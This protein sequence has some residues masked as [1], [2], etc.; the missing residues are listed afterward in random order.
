MSI[1]LRKN[2]VIS[3][4]ILFFVFNLQAK[5]NPDFP[6]I[7]QGHFPSV[8]VDKAD[9]EVVSIAANALAND[10]KSVTGNPS[11]VINNTEKSDVLIIAGTLGKSA[12]IDKLAK[13]HKINAKAIQG[14]WETYSI[15]YVYNPFNGVK[16][17][18]VVAGSDRRATAYGIFE[19]SKMMGVSPWVWWA[20]VLPEKKQEL[21]IKAENKVYGEPSVKYRGIFLNDED[22]GLKPWA[23]KNMDTDIKDIG[24]NTYAHIFELLLRLKANYIWPAMHDCTKAFYYYP[25]NPV[26][27]DKYAIVV[28]SS[29]CEPI[30]RNNVFEWA[31]NFENEYGTKPGEWRYDKNKAQIDKY[32]DDRA[33]QSA[34][35]ESVYTIGMRG[36]H[37]GSMPGPKDINQKIKLLDSVIVDQ[38][39][40][41][42]NRLHKPATQIPQIFCPYKEV[43]TLYQKGLDLPDDATIVWA[44]DNHGY[45]RQ[46]SNEKEQKR[47]GR[48][49]VY[50]HLSYWGSPHDYLWLSSVSPSL[51]SFEMTKAYDFGADRLWVFNVGDIKPAEAEIQFA[52][53]LAWDIN[54]WTPE[55]AREYSRYWAAETFGEKYADKIA[56]IKQTYYQLAQAAKPEHV[57]YVE[58]SVSEQNN[59]MEEYSNIAREAEEL[60]ADIPDYLQ[61]AYFQL[62]Y[63][64]VMGAKLMNEKIFY[65]QQSLVLMQKGDSSCLNYAGKS[66]SAFNQIQALTKQ[67]NKEISNGKWD[68]IMDWQPRRQDVFKMPETATKEGLEKV[69]AGKTENKNPDSTNTV[70]IPANQIAYSRVSRDRDIQILNGLGT[71]G[72]CVTIFPLTYKPTNEEDIKS[73]PFV[74]YNIPAKNGQ[75][76]VEVR[77]LPTHPIN[78]EYGLRFGISVN[79]DGPQIFDMEAPENSAQWKTDV[80]RGYHSK[81]TTHTV[82]NNEAVIRIYFPDPGFVLDKIIVRSEK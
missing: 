69:L 11:K 24:P 55:K 57:P 22:W 28:G 68:G 1:L 30:L 35:Y 38:R 45:I 10:A 14:K 52:M 59:R 20:D 77:S 66:L 9:A 64:P 74:E 13:K 51:I 15:S 31:E 40:I 44:D 4:L 39:D 33:K 53:D 65:A 71:S 19:I 29:H 47:S 50:Y 56:S 73:A 75:I 2:T 76:E 81:T 62:I 16:R 37:D 67:Y 25:G 72:K 6:L 23:A 80:L 42:S 3:T 58:F 27:A 34:G 79:S 48:S 60:K 54:S 7:N 78:N 43:L 8:L 82:T 63:Y 26:M 18:I 36:I 70:I 49:G 5:N 41:L 21:T 61:D 12:F 46:L 17:A 32:W